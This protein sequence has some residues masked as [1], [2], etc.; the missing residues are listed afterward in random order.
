[1]ISS[2]T[3]NV[4][5]LHTNLFY[6]RLIISLTIIK[7]VAISFYKKCQQKITTMSSTVVIILLVIILD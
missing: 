6:I 3:L 2:A 5:L 1:M 7:R 4:L